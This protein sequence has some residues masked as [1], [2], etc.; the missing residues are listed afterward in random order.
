MKNAINWF[1]IPTR[2]LDKAV[3]FYEAVLGQPI[4]RE[5]FGGVPHG[6]LSA[7][8]DAVAGALVADAKRTPGAG[9]TLIYLDCTGGVPGAVERAK[10]AGAQIVLPVTS[11]GPFG[12]IAVIRDLDGNEVGLHAEAA[13]S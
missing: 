1:E 3:T 10:Q 12:W 7:D 8:K 6:V 2:D 13:A 9:G 11:I 4:K 5:D